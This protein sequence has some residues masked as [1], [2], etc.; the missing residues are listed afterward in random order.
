[1]FALDIMKSIV[2]IVILVFVQLHYAYVLRF[3]LRYII[4]LHYV[5]CKNGKMHDGA[6]NYV[7]VYIVGSSDTNQAQ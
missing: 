7:I 3:T 2:T 5:Y 4:L 1:M 6:H